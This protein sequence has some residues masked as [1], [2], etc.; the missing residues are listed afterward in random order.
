MR[1]LYVDSRDRVTGTTSDFQI[2]LREALVSSQA[3]SFRI[4]SLRIPLVVPLIRTG[5][6]DDIVFQLSGAPKNTCILI[7]GNYSGTDLAAH[8]QSRLAAQFP[9]KTW[10]ATYSNSTAG[11]KITC[12]DANFKILNDAECAALSVVT[13]T[14]ASFLFQN[15]HTQV[16]G[17][18]SFSYCPI[19]AIDTFYV[20]EPGRG[21]VQSAKAQEIFAR[22]IEEA[23]VTNKDLYPDI[24]AQAKKVRGARFGLDKNPADLGGLPP[25][26]EVYHELSM[27]RTIVEV[28]A[29][30]EIGLLF[31]LA[32]L[33][34]DHGFDITFARIG[35]ERDVAIDSFYI[36]NARPAETV[37]TP[38][39]EHLR[40]AIHLAISPPA[41]VAA[42]G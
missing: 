36:E 2:Q 12:N 17:V 10:T 5:Y 30:D 8:I 37:Q 32:K 39:L 28:Q 38:R 18:T 42:T 3:N 15:T 16:A 11:L 34:S 9:S 40:D 27:Q 13:P 41:P 22:T 14:F 7:G 35:T 20:V 26:V 21:V 25:T 23:L 4:D 29:R 19:I 1:C 31:K 24:V 33:I 6:N